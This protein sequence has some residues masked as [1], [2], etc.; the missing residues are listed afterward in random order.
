MQPAQCD[1]QLYRGDYFE[2]TLRLREGTINGST[3]APG[4]YLDLTGWQPKAEIRASVDST[5]PP[6][7]T[8]TTEVMDQEIAGTKGG[9]HVFL[10]ADTTAALTATNAV[11]D[12]QLTDTLDRVYTYLRG[13]VT[14]TKD[15]TR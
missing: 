12:V 14:I 10:P 9:V 1:I 6:L 15:V 13:T 11:W 2:M 4:A 7:A 8:F 3:Y 5:G